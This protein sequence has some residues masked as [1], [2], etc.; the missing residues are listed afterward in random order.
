MVIG[1]ERGTA[2]TTRSPGRPRLYQPDAERDRILAATLEVLRR[3]SGQEATVADILE[4]AGL[5]TRAFY[6][7]FETKE[8][9]ILAVYKRDAESFSAHLSRRIDAADD[10]NEALAVWVHEIL[11]LA[12]DRRRAERVSALQSPMVTR[13]VSGTREQQL[14]TDLLEEPLRSVLEDGLAQGSFPHARPR[15]RQPHHPRHRL[16]GSR[17][18]SDPDAETLATRGG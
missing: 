3:N 16:G 10:P 9:V 18:G 6:R 12:Y 4:E 17:L 8:D 14:G 1:A 2:V 13:V 5:S 15:T 11:G 7:H